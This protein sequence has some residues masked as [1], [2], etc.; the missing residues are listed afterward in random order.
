MHWLGG[1]GEAVTTVWADREDRSGLT[2][3]ADRPP[4][5]NRTI[6]GR[7]AN[8]GPASCETQWLTIHATQRV[9]SAQIRAAQRGF[10]QNTLH[11]AGLPA[12]RHSRGQ[13][14]IANTCR[15]KS[16]HLH[17]AAGKP[18]YWSPP[19]ASYR[20]IVER[21]VAWGGPA[22]SPT[23]SSPHVFI[24]RHASAWLGTA[25]L[26]SERPSER[27]IYAGDWANPDRRPAVRG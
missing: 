23:P 10:I 3:P 5:L 13:A 16:N 15:R 11:T 1:G 24:K 27:P 4:P 17:T 12:P 14:C 6:S 20:I 22:S 18:V 26:G 9:L 21:P 8:V 25:R 19:V 7:R 2:G